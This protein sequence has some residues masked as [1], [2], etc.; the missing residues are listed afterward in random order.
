MIFQFKELWYLPQQNMAIFWPQKGFLCLQKGCDQ[1]SQR[2]MSMFGRNSSV[3]E[4][5]IISMR[6]G[7]GSVVAGTGC[8]VVRQRGKCVQTLRITTNCC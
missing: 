1:W 4:M 6:G 2:N 5:I 8:G 7:T 3:C